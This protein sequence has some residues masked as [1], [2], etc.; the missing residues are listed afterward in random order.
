MMGSFS[1]RGV[2]I[3][4]ALGCLA[5]PAGAQDARPAW[6]DRV[7][8]R[9]D[10]LV[11]PAAVPGMTL[12][13]ALPDGSTLAFAAGMADTARH[14]AMHPEAL[15]LQGSVGKTYF[16]AVALQLVAEG[17]IG[18]DRPIADY[19]G[20]APW[21]DRIPNG[22]QATVRQVMGQTSGI[23]RYEFN[24]AFLEDLTADPYR[25]FTPEERLAYLFDTEARSPPARGGSIRTRTTS[26]WP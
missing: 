6:A 16:G 23:V 13:V 2:L 18:L 3:V 7:Q 25:T 14:E 12:G 1:A 20:D 22:R 9:L 5:A 17:R 19:L 4:A 24:P 26:W 8:A 21:F 11:A 15:M 10:S